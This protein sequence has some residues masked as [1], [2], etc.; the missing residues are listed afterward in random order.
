M[1]RINVYKAPFTALFLLEVLW[2]GV[3]KR[4][5]S[6]RTKL[7]RIRKFEKAFWSAFLRILEDAS[8]LAKRWVVFSLFLSKVLWLLESWTACTKM[9]TSRS[10]LQFESSEKNCS[11]LNLNVIRVP[12]FFTF[13]VNLLIYGQSHLKKTFPSDT[14]VCVRVSQ[15][16]K[17]GYWVNSRKSRTSFLYFLLN[18]RS[19]FIHESTLGWWQI[20]FFRHDPCITVQWYACVQSCRQL[21]D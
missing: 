15:L 18:S 7:I 13:P 16:E 1:V 17:R 11:F 19:A 2:N 14:S 8:L 21:I 4:E 3:W 6:K 9:K 12:S 10:L 20:R 5:S